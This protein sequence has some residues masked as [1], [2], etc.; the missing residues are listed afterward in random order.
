MVKGSKGSTSEGSKS[1]GSTS[2][3]VAGSELWVSQLEQK[4][5]ELS[6]AHQAIIGANVRRAQGIERGILQD[7]VQRT[8]GWV[9]EMG[10]KAVMIDTTKTK[11]VNARLGESDA[12]VINCSVDLGIDTFFDGDD[13]VT[14]FET[15]ETLT[16]TQHFLHI[17]IVDEK[18]KE[19]E[20]SYIVETYIGVHLEFDGAA[21]VCARP[22]LYCAISHIATG[23]GLDPQAERR[24]RGGPE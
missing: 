11:Q 7:F 19:S 18:L 23:A 16:F 8:L 4:V 24:S 21:K 15:E 12:V 9:R 14:L 20:K 3:S 5:T 10:P 17:K 13:G 2:E 1:E 22:F 6:K